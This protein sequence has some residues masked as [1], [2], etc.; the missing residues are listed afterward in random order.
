MVPAATTPALAV[1]LTGKRPPDDGGVHLGISFDQIAAR[2][3][4]KQ[5]FLPSLQLGGEPAT[6]GPM[7]CAL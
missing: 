6:V 2:K 5:T 4:G 3:V 1:F 7:R